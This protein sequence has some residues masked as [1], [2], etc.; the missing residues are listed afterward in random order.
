[1]DRL[2][3]YT[4]F[5]PLSLL[6]TAREVAKSFIQEVVWLHGFPST[7]VSEWDKIFLSQFWTELFRFPSTK[8]KFSSAYHPQSDGQTEA[9]NKCLETYLRCLTGGKPKQWK[10]WLAWAEFWFNTTYSGSTK[11]TPFKALYGRDPPFIFKGLLPT[12]EVE[13]VNNGLKTEML[14][15]KSWELICWELKTA[16]RL[17]QSSWQKEERGA[18]YR[19]GLGVPQITPSSD[20]I[21]SKE[22]IRK[23]RSANGWGD[24]D[25]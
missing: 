11:L 12:S 21:I 3:K 15:C 16:W 24:T 4:H 19:G 1:M 9:V 17:K 20:E 8:L 5:I 25:Y 18:V 23:I 22:E 13:E 6:F 7:I 2:T 10:K 14:F